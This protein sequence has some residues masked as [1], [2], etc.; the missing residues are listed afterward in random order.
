MF[1]SALASGAPAA[2]MLSMLG[3]MRW[4]MR[5]VIIVVGLVCE[6]D[7]LVRVSGG[8]WRWGWV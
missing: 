8:A 6:E 7:D 1:A 4:R 3:M 2:R 5:M